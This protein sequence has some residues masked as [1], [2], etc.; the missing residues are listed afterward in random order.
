[1]QKVQFNVHETDLQF[2]AIIWPG[3]VPEFM[4]I[5]IEI[6]TNRY[7]RESVLGCVSEQL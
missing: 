6:S 5:Y 1:M 4:K 7:E 3:I 2:R